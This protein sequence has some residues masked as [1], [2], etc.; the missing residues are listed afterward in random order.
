ML[1]DPSGRLRYPPEGTGYEH[2]A[3][4]AW[5][6]RTNES[7]VVN[8]TFNSFDLED[9]TECR[10]DW[11]QINDGR[12]AAAQIIGRYCG[13]HL[14][15]GGSIISSGNQLYLWFRS[16]NSTAKEGFDLTW[17]SM[18]PQ[19]GGRLEFETHGTLASPG[20]PGNYPKNR[21]CRWQLV[22]VHFNVPRIL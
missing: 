4:C 22:V 17:S 9:S 13:N 16:D 2:N 19:C 18:Q 7:L 20:S 3:Q 21:D 6:I 8:V 10:F 14:P 5:V 15:H 11:L 12:S 1:S